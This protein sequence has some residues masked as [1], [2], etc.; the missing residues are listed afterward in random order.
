MKEFFRIQRELMRAREVKVGAILG[1]LAF[2]VCMGN[3]CTHLQPVPPSE[4][5][6]TA[7]ATPTPDDIVTPATP[8]ATPVPMAPARVA[9]SWEKGHAERA[10]WSDQLNALMQE[11]WPSLSQAKDMTR[12]CPKYESLTLEQKQKAFAEMI[13]GISYFESAWSPVSRMQESTMGTDPITG[14]A[15]YS[16]GLL[17]LSYQDI[18]WAKYCKFDWAKDKALDPKSPLKTILNPAL[19]LD[20]GVR[21]LAD[22]V[23]SKKAVVLSKS[24]YW[25]VIKDGGKYQQIPGIV[26]LVQKAM[27]ECK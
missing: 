24:V 10:P 2:V 15:V 1:A 23:A 7:Q 13:V 20:C 6:P 21:I 19:N 17:Q 27:P 11:L 14:R 4:L 26:S 3:A 5:A 16:E 9:L 12:F 18:I 25:A 8:S 22:Q